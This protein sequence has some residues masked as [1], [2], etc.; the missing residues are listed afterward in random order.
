MLKYALPSWEQ[1][2]EP[3]KHQSEPLKEFTSSFSEKV[4][5]SWE[6]VGPLCA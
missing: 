1:S 4:S 5:Q 6:A 2:W 3:V